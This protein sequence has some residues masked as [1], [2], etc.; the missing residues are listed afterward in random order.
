MAYIYLDTKTNV[1]SVWSSSGTGCQVML[2]S[3]HPQRFSAVGWRSP[4]ICC[5]NPKGDFILSRGLDYTASR[6]PFPPE[7]FSNWT[8]KWTAEV[9][10]YIYTSKQ[11]S[12]TEYFWGAELNNLNYWNSPGIILD[13]PS[14]Q[15]AKAFTGTAG[16]QHTPAYT[17][18]E[19]F[20]CSY[21]LEVAERFQQCGQKFLH[22]SWHQC[23]RTVPDT[24]VY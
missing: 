16:R 6:G 1:H 13:C 9:I 14:Q 12:Y 24:F 8:Q 5:S 10:G 4:Q 3:L 17:V 11:H 15:A 18:N 2:W 21:V 20:A 22:D 23:W 7:L 19:Q